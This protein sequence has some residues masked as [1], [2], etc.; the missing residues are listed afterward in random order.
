MERR[1]AVA[2]YFYPEN[3]NE[4]ES[5]IRKVY[6]SELGASGKIDQEFP[7]AINGVVCPHAGIIFSGAVASW[8][9]AVLSRIDPIDTFI[10][11]GPN[12]RGLGRRASLSSAE[13]WI[14]PLGKIEVDQ[15]MV[16]YFVSSSGIFSID[17]RAHQYEHSCE[18]H[19]PFL[20]QFIPFPF[21]I[22]PISLLDQTMETAQ[23][24]SQ[25][26]NEFSQRKKIVIIASTD[27]THYES[28]TMAREKD[29]ICI[30]NI[31]R[32][33]GDEFFHCIHRNQVSICGPG[34]VGTLI[35]FQK[36]RHS[37][38][39]TLLCYATSGDINGQYDQV[40]GYAAIAFPQ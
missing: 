3:K 19:L 13:S 26:I 39:G 14:T 29:L 32:L 25:V 35:E 7:T 11:I 21:K 22:C 5:L 12:H 2:G 37:P 8:A 1:P 15:E 10:I 9:Y 36:I 38:R 20:Q 40:V 31:V 27:F 23:K 18:I 30:D 28:D 34:G 33:D 24:M 17:D 16:D 4:L 6:E